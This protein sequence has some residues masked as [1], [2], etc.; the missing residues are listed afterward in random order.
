MIISSAEKPSENRATAATHLY[1]KREVMI[2]LGLFALGVLSRLPFV[3][4]V[5]YHWDSINF[6][7]GLQHFDVA[8]G[9]PHVPGYILYVLLGQLINSWVNNP[10]LTLTGISVVG[11]GLAVMALYGL[12][13]TMFNRSIGLLAAFLLASSPLYWFYGEIALP[14]SLDAFVIVG[15]VWLLYRIKQGQVALAVPAAIWLGLAGGFRPQ[16]EVFLAPLALYACWGLGWRRAL[17]AVMVLAVVNLAWV[18]PLIW[19]TGGLARYLEVT[20]QF[21]LA[22]NAT[23]SIVNG[24]GLWGLSRNLIKLTLYTLYGWGLALIPV[25]ALVVLKAKRLTFQTLS[26]TLKDSRFWFLALWIGPTLAYYMF[27]HM[28]QQGLVFVFLP[29]LLL[30]SAGGVYRLDWTQSFYQ[31]VALAVL[32]LTN[33]LI[34]VLAPTFPL[35]SE[36]LK[37][38]SA[39]TLRHHDAYY[40][41]RLEAMPQNFPETQT[42]LLASEWRFP[43]YYL[44]HYLLA[45]YSIVARWELGEGSST[46][47]GEVWVDGAQAGLTPDKDGFFYAVL[48]DDK[49]IPFNHSQDR[50]E[51]LELSNG[52]KLAYLRFSSEER[53]Y[54]GSQSFG[55]VPAP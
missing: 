43:Q 37:L 26:S 18:V 11:S 36:R 40:L 31:Q 4:Q 6:A 35:G 19:S 8:A 1:L 38:L 50:L 45:P 3:G 23:T 9:Q 5:L 28:G 15:A 39:E 14:H 48:F 21:Y 32:V 24:G 12:G 49:L 46:R 33:A 51:W 22:F 2:G 42:L 10:Q 7:L 13:R 30:L 29:A 20:N 53:L 54:I 47:S 52:Q 41:S 44:P 17:V 16:T 27:I 34:F 25:L 55:I